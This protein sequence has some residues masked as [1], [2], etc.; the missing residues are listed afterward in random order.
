MW[1][2]YRTVRSNIS[3]ICLQTSRMLRSGWSITFG[4][5]VFRF[6]SRLRFARA[7]N[8]R[9][10]SGLDAPLHKDPRTWWVKPST[11]TFTGTD[12]I[13]SRYGFGNKSDG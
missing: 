8:K 7:R 11:L 10:S 2:T 9:R 13:R 4:R 1:H 6:K 5:P 12:E 3:K